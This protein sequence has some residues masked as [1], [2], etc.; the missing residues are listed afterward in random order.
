MNISAKI[1][2]SNNLDTPITFKIPSGSVIEAVDAKENVQN[3]ALEREYTFTVPKN[4]TITVNVVGRCL[5]RTRNLPSGQ[6]GRL[7]PFRYA[8]IDFTQDVVWGRVSQPA[9]F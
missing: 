6:A 4:S 1:T 2:L 7:T 3:I 8:G 5:N 9:F